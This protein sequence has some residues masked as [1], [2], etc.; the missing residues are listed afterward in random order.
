MKFK[1]QSIDQ[2]KMNWN[3]ILTGFLQLNF[4]QVVISHCMVYQIPPQT[5]EMPCIPTMAE[6]GSTWQDVHGT[7]G[8]N[9]TVLVAGE[10]FLCCHW[11]DTYMN[12]FAYT[13]EMEAKALISSRI[14]G[15][16]LQQIDSFWNLQFWTNETTEEL[17]CIVKL[18]TKSPYLNEDFTVNL[19]HALTDASLESAST[20][21][22]KENS[23]VTHCNTLKAQKYECQISSIKLNHIYIMW[24]KITNGTILLQS[25]LMSVKPIDIVKPDPPLYLQVEMTET[26]Q[27]KIS[28]SQPASKSNLFLY[29]VKCFT[30]STKNFQQVAEI[31]M[32]TSLTINNELLKSSYIIQVRCKNH[33]ELGLWSDWSSPFNMDLQDV[34]Y[35][36]SKLL[37]SVGTN[38]SFY[39]VYKTKDK[40]I[41]SK[42]IVWWLNLAKEIPS[43]QYTLV[44]DYTSKVTLTN[45]PAMK[46]GGKFLFNALYCCNENKE[47]NHRY[48]ELYI[49]DANIKITCETYGNLQ[50]MTCSWSINPDPILL[51]ST[52]LL[53]Y[54]RNDIYCS[55]SP[56]MHSDSE[57]K[58]CNLRRN[59]VYDPDG[60]E[61]QH[62]VNFYVILSL[63]ISCSL[64]LL[65]ALLILQH[66][67]KKLL[68]VDVPNPKNCSW[69]QGVNFQKPET[70]EHL[71]LKHPE[72]LPFGPLLLE[73]E[74]VLED[75]SIDKVMKHEDKQEL[76]AVDSLFSTIQDFEH[77][78]ICTSGLFNSDSLSEN[79][80]DAE[81]GGMSEQ[82][83]V[84]YATI[85]S[86]SMSSGLYEPPKN[87]SSPF[88]RSFVNLKSS[89]P[90]SFSSISWAVGNQAFLILP[91]YFQ[92]LPRKTHT[93]SVISSEG[94]SESSEHDKTFTEGDSPERSLFYLG[95][96][97][98]KNNENDIFLTENSNV[99][100][101]NYHTN[102][103]IRSMRISQTDLNSF[104]CNC[105]RPLQTFIPYMPQFQTLT[106][107]IHETASRKA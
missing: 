64:L 52:L 19:L 86:G 83:N 17:F 60:I 82:C 62:D 72:A 55:E 54:Y 51:E 58:G 22:L 57:V 92:D 44:N 80:H 27:I 40:M 37:A 2:N 20:N 35:F 101:C 88:D 28:W 69:A 107:K 7:I 10:N 98:L 26:G 61:K 99:A 9:A 67:I 65:G 31:T 18:S 46:P 105:E 97:P 13:A 50:K 45:L 59:N 29:E 77:D 25:P 41:S 68:W 87:S 4:F 23:T 12:C 56:S 11:S 66:R 8:D 70:F 73:S 24:L 32:G 63:M 90:A 103:I 48:A 15:S 96:G 74:I 3:N 85:I 78:S 84:K 100:P 5:F 71:F 53:R 95:M 16:T 30:N 102:T 21:L 42:K 14:V 94:F 89:V 43:S 79:V 75:I 47:C 6:D 81:K 33:Q 104:I 49:I 39:C 38:V 1:I 34:M 36:P 106:V 76:L 91:E 93:L